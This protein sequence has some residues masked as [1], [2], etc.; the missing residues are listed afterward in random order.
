VARTSRTGAKADTMS[1]TGAVTAFATPFS[2]HVVRMDMES[3]PTGM[4]MP[5][6]TQ[7]SIAT[8]RTVS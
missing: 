7:V 2:L 1:D 5:R 6:R 8:A 3:L 4:A